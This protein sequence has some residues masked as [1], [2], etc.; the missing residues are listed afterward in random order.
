M[1]ADTAGRRRSSADGHGADGPAP[2]RDKLGV[3]QWFHF[4]DHAA[5]DLTVELLAE[6]GVRHLRTGISWADYFRDGG[7]A[8]YDW[9]MRQLKEFDV[10]LS[11]WHTPPSIS[12]GDACSSP[13]RRLRDFADFIAAVDPGGSRR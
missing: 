1:S 5:V 6:L 10:L 2:L 13:P 7:P 12:E 3:C 8:W 9:Q 11:V 4:Q